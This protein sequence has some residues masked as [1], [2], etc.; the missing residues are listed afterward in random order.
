[1][2]NWTKKVTTRAEVEVFI[3]NR[4]YETLPRPPFSV[5]ETEDIAGR[6]YQYVWQRSASGQDL[7]AA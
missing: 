4:L 6:V 2:D 5:A 1:M 7:L 3:L